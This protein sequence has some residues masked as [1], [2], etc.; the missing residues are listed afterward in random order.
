MARVSAALL[1]SLALAACGPLPRPF[2]AAPGAESNP[3]VAPEESLV[4]RVAAVDGPPLPLARMLAG[5]VAEALGALNVAAVARD[6]GTSRYVLKGRAEV[7]RDHRLEPYM[8]LIDWTLVNSDGDVIGLHTQGVEGSWVQW[9][10]GDPGLV[11]AVGRTAAKPLAALIGGDEAPAAFAAAPAALLLVPVR[12]APGD[13][14]RSLARA[15]RLA[16]EATDVGMTDHAAKATHFLRGTVSVTPPA[17]GRQR[18]RVVWTVTAAGGAQVARLTQESAVPEG[19]VDG[20]WN[21][22]SAV[23][24]AAVAADI[25]KAL[26]R[27]QTGP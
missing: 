15:M 27:M 4:V 9:E 22:L 13:G 6:S 7:N 26:G 12:G 18:V 17:A 25:E 21:R 11:R 24:A 10:Y 5:A 1:L 14:D 2:Q 19:G 8:V 16:L 23:I 20:P 3:L